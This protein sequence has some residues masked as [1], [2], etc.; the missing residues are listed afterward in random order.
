MPVLLIPTYLAQSP[1]H[2]LG[3][4]AGEAIPQG[5]PIWEFTPGFDLDLSEALLQALP[6]ISQRAMRHYGYI[7][8]RLQRFILCADDYRFANHSAT[9]NVAADLSQSP[10]GI[11]R[12]VRDIDADE[13]LTV[14]YAAVE[15]A[16][17]RG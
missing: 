9:P 14:D 10:Y 1:I 12:A 17:P 15:G 13:E 6:Q 11:D 7:D 16:R 2:G 4:F 5:T 8:P 3:L